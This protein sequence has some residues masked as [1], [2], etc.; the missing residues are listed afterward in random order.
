MKNKVWVVEIKTMRGRYEPCAEAKL[1]LKDAEREMRDYW[2]HNNPK[3]TFRAKK[4]VP[5]K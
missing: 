5:A 2:M 4:Y 3:D 1:T